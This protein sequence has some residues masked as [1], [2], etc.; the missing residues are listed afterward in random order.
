MRRRGRLY[1][2]GYG[3]GLVNGVA[4]IVTQAPELAFNMIA[5]VC[6]LLGNAMGMSW[7]LL[8]EVGKLK[9]EQRSGGAKG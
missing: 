9:S 7:D 2:I 6:M 3:I 8:V 1:T 4:M 5:V